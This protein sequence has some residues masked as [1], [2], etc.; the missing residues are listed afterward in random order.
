MNARGGDRVTRGDDRADKTFVPSGGGRC[1]RR[2]HEV[3]MREGF[4]RIAYCLS[5]AARAMALLLALVLV[6][7]LCSERCLAAVPSARAEYGNGTIEPEDIIPEEDPQSV[8]KAAT[9]GPEEPTQKPKKQ[10]AA[11]QYALGVILAGGIAIGMM[12]A[13]FFY[14]TKQNNGH[15]E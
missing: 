4:G 12:I 7:L 2:G 10:L 5:R 3:C 15:Q 11:E 8:T 6:V 14:Y 9:P 1:P 13:L